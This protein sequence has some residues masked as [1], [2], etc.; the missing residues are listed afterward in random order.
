MT[1]PNNTARSR[2]VATGGSS[3]TYVNAGDGRKSRSSGGTGATGPA[4]HVVDR[5]SYSPVP[6]IRR[7][8]NRVR[9]VRWWQWLIALAVLVI[10]IRLALPPIL[11]SVMASQASQ[12]L[13]ARVEIGDVDLALLRGGVALVDV[14]VR[15]AAKEPAAGEV[16][17]AP[18]ATQ[19]QTE[20]EGAAAPA[21]SLPLIGWKRLA[22]ELDW[23]P[24]FSKTI[25]LHAIELESP[26]VA[27]D[28]LESGD[29]NLAA[30][31]PKSD[32]E[33]VPKTEAEASTPWGFG[34][35]R[36]ALSTGKLRFHDLM[37]RDTEPVDISLDAIEV[38]EVAVRPEMYG[39]PANVHLEFK[40]DDGTLTVDARLSVLET[41]VAVDAD[42]KADHL[43]VHRSRSYIPNARWNQLDGFLGMAL[44]YRMETEKQ[45]EISGAIAL[46][47]VTARRDGIEQ[48]VL[49]W[50][51]F[52]VT[53]DS[54]DLIAQNAKIATVWVD[55]LAL[56]VRAKGDDPLPAMSF[57]PAAKS[58]PEPAPPASEPPA[59]TAPPSPQEEAAAAKP[60]Q[61]S[62]GKIELTDAHAVV[63]DAQPPLDVGIKLTLSDLRDKPEQPSPLQLSIAAAN[64]TL[65]LDGALRTAPPGF[66]GQVKIEH[67]DLPTLLAAAGVVPAQPLRAATL[68]ADLKIALG[69]S[70]PIAGD[71]Q[72]SGTIAL[73]QVHVVGDNE[74]EFMAGGDAIEVSLDRVRLPGLMNPSSAAA[75][76]EPI[77]V[78]IGTVR[79]VKPVAQL[80]NTDNGFVLPRFA[81]AEAPAT[82]PVEPPPA[83]AQAASSAPP[84]VIV[85]VGSL[86]V[87]G[88]KIGFTDRT[89]SP[90]YVGTIAGLTLDVRDAR[91]PEQAVQTFALKLSTPP[92]GTLDVRGSLVQG[93]GNVDVDAKEIGLLP[94]NPYSMKF[95]PFTIANGALTLKT[96]AKIDGKKYG[97]TNAITLQTFD[98]GGQEGDSLFQEQFGIPLSLALSLLRDLNGNI[99][100][101]VP[102]NVDEKGTSVGIGTIVAGA[103]RGALVG[104]LA[105]PLKLF[106]AVVQGGKVQALAP[107]TIAFRPGRDEPV[108]GGDTQLQQLGAFLA[109]RPTIGLTLT[110]APTESDARWLKEQAL[111]AEM[112]E[113]QGFFGVIRTLGQRDERRQIADALEARRRDE[114]GALEGE[115][116]EALERMLAERPNPTAE[117]LRT[118]AEARLTRIETTLRQQPGVNAAR[119]TR[120]EIASEASKDQPIVRLTMAPAGDDS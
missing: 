109:S 60:W 25:R 37:M 46:D 36:F 71:V 53:I 49:A 74:K 39:Q 18:A 101:D 38:K 88:G 56:P 119:I 102:V 59:S 17:E 33:A 41:G 75:A 42:I 117:Q 34:I 68:E 90:Q 72:V 111:R 120:G 108:A 93:K 65:G 8:W 31:V 104:A 114:K 105:S 48:P 52:N 24:L 113:P 3:V 77:T 66:D 43:P 112:G 30:L 19:P 97:V 20:G 61:W 100:L 91:W 9:R 15:E 69:S 82:P 54:I 16:A 14:A 118:L 84:G 27:V 95:S 22:V 10:A 55:G 2:A 106:G 94:F 35:D 58:D 7:I 11:R 29:I 50:K 87:N 12:L 107:P 78:D 28:R 89:V 26:F 92:Q 64:G 110:T 40:V 23:L 81:S 44:K 76:Q 57:A 70:A 13:N 103:L 1:S 4:L 79:I 99:T 96:K 98:L 73:R 80:T 116:A 63:I 115:A 47:A 62:V 21:E 85:K 5:C 45:N 83:S 86:Q 67:L 32:P 6:M 51:R